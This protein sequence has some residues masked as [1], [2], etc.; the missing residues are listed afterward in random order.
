MSTL[1]LYLMWRARG[2]TVE[3]PAVQAVVSLRSCPRSGHPVSWLWVPA[4]AGTISYSVSKY[5]SSASFS[6]AGN[7]VPKVCPALLLPIRLVS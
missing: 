2:M 1:E 6:A 7:V 4:F 3:T 5:A